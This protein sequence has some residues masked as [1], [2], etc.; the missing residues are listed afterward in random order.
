MNFNAGD[1]S[2]TRPSAVVGK[3]LHNTQRQIRQNV[4]AW[5]DGSQK[6]GPNDQGQLIMR[7]YNQYKDEENKKKVNRK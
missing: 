3:S 2:F 1:P 4:R 6:W 5:L 7:A